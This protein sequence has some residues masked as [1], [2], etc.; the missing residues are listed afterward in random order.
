MDT[1]N[2]IIT[3][4]LLKLIT[5][6]DEFKGGWKS[7][8]SLSPDRL[9]S[10]RHVATIESIGSSTRIEG[11]KLSDQQ[12]EAV[13]T[14]IEAKSFETRDE[15]EVVGY[16]EVMETLYDNATDI[17]FTENYIKQFHISLLRHSNKDERH[18]GEY[19]K[20]PSNI[21]AFTPEGESLGIVFE[22][23][24]PF[25]TP[26]KMERLVRWTRE[27]LEDKSLHPLIVIGVFIVT[28]L[29]IHPFQDGNG[30]LSRVLTSLLLLKSG[31]SYIPFSSMESIIEKNKEAY[32]LNLRRT[33]SSLS[34]EKTDWI[35]W[36]RFF[37]T[38]LKRQKDH[39]ETKLSI[40][41]SEAYQTLSADSLMILE[42]INKHGRITTA[43]AHSLLKVSRPTV[44]TRLTRLT[45]DGYILL[46]GQGR[47][48]HYI[49]R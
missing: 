1:R 41:L 43:Q 7:M 21:E 16:A 14:G 25:E 11:V 23:A 20:L 40:H 48:S 49:K 15:Q 47:G 3:P 2:L 13:L 9:Q 37:L 42:Y 34:H 35:P 44:K 4:E 45:E 38:S 22:T 28:F 8:Q 5:E 10:L 32:Y 12:V 30:R 39:L 36:L 19:K 18:R 31:Y 46:Q 26:L 17:P 6:I 27:T 29:A 24:T 33:Q